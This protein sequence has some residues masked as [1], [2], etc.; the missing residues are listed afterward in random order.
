MVNLIL[1][2]R[3][4]LRI[5]HEV[6]FRT[7]NV[8]LNLRVVSNLYSQLRA[9]LLAFSFLELGITGHLIH[10]HNSVEKLDIT[11]T[12]SLLIVQ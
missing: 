4:L 11:H 9:N 10:R 5:S 8:V 7:A 1:F 2:W 12:I 3:C 6:S